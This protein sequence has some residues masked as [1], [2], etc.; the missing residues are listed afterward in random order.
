MYADSVV[1]K[2]LVKAVVGKLSSSHVS[3]L[4]AIE[5]LRF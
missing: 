1:F 5:R 2:S 4:G 3:K